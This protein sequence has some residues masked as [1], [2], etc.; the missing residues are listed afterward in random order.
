MKHSTQFTF[1]SGL[2]ILT[3]LAFVVAACAT[4]TTQTSATNPVSAAQAP[5]QPITVQQSSA[6]KAAQPQT[7]AILPSGFAAPAPG[8]NLLATTWPERLGIIV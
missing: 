5:V 8:P 7:A 6:P 1:K 4:P 3:A 2:L